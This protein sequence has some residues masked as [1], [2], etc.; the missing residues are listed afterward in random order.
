VTK[1]TVYPAFIPYPKPWPDGAIPTFIP[2]TGRT[3]P[4]VEGRPWNIVPAQPT[5]TDVNEHQFGIY[6][7]FEGTEQIQQLVISRAISGLHIR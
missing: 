7:L 3:T 6:D 4:D 5:C 2:T 1:S